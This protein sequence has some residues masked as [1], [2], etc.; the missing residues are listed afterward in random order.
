MEQPGRLK[1]AWGE[2]GPSDALRGAGTAEV[3]APGF[4]GAS[5][6]VSV[7]RARGRLE[8]CGRKKQKVTVRPQ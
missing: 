7:P 4:R 8:P 6:P 5:R 2:L 3:G 1:G